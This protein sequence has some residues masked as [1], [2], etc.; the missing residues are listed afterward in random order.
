MPSV[1]LMV[2][3]AS[4]EGYHGIVLLR[5]TLTLTAVLSIAT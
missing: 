5:V 2:H 3:F 1:L 4:L